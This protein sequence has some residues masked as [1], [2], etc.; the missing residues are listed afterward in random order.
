M[1]GARKRKK[2][3]ETPQSGV[4]PAHLTE[5]H[6]SLHELL[7]FTRGPLLDTIESMEMERE[8]ARAIL[9]EWRGRGDSGAWMLNH[10]LNRLAV[11]LK[12]E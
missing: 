8:E 2:L 6:R 9:K 11:A 1:A 12:M 3:S 5:E 10:Y 4:Q 7:N